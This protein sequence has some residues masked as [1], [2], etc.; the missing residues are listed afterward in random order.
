MRDEIRKINDKLYIGMGAMAA[1]GGTI[2]PM[3]FILSGDQAPWVGPDE[4]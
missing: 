4:K 2:N 3:P 1:S